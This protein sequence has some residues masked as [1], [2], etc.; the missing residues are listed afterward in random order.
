MKFIKLLSAVIM[1]ASVVSCGQKATTKED[2]K[3]ELD[4]V[5]YALG[6]D[7]GRNDCCKKG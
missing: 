3:T 6:M 4:S 2:L 7:V 1:T 5:S